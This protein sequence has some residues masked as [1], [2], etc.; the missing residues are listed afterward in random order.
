MSLYNDLSAEVMRLLSEFGQSVT[1][2]RSTPGAY[3]HATG[4]VV[5]TTSTQSGIGAV[6]EYKSGVTL[7]DGN[8][9]QQ[10]DKKLLLGAVSLTA[11]IIGDIVIANGIS[12]E[13][14]S[15]KEINPANSIVMYI[16]N[17]RGV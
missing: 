3:D 5:L 13:I 4:L 15:I 1:I 8:L 6:F 7:F 9:I 10:G 2:T 14:K 17:I 11:P 12:Y 16:C